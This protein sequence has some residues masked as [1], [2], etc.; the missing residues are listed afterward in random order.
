MSSSIYTPKYSLARNS[1]WAEKVGKFSNNYLAPATLVASMVTGTTRL[2][3]QNI[4]FNNFNLNLDN[5]LS[6]IAA[7]SDLTAA[8]MNVGVR[9]SSVIGNILRT[10]LNGMM[11]SNND[12]LQNIANQLFQFA[13]TF[14]KFSWALSE[15]PKKVEKIKKAK[16]FGSK[17][18]KELQESGKWLIDLGKKEKYQK[19]NQEYKILGLKGFIG[20]RTYSLLMASAWTGLVGGVLLM[21]GNA[22][23]PTLKLNALDEDENKQKEKQLESN[24]IW[25]KLGWY[26]TKGSLIFLTLSY[27]TKSFSP[28][29]KKSNYSIAP[30]LSMITFGATA[31]QAVVAENPTLAQYTRFLSYF[32]FIL[33]WLETH[34]LSSG[35]NG[36]TS[37]KHRS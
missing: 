17:F 28:N 16:N 34:K 32:S 22:L 13:S 15:Q 10:I 18:I 7:A 23:N 25:H 31:A 24:S 6:V 14:I 8:G 12:N 3:Q 11:A 4:S 5:A 37:A 20:E 33:S 1:Q 30:L 2:C 9:P 27:L 29:Y 35:L 26:F 21:I 36:L 19:L